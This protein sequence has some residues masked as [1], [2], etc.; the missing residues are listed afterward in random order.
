MKSH[1]AREYEYLIEQ[2]V[3]K[4]IRCGVAMCFV[5]NSGD[6]GEEVERFGEVL[7]EVG[8]VERGVFFL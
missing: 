4:A 8:T 6:L 5:W 1:E 2:R 3:R 7:R